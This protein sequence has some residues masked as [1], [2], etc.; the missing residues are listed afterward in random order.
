[1][2]NFFFCFVSAG[3]P[4]FG[5]MPFLVTPEGKVLGSS[6]AIMKYISKKGGTV[7]SSDILSY[8]SEIFVC[9]VHI[10]FFFFTL[11]LLVSPGWISLFFWP[12]LS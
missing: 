1:M 2:I 6:V 5:Q 8:V 9:R 11:Y 3:R 10:F 7:I 12:I 4:P